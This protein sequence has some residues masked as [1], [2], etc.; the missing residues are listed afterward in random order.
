MCIRDRNRTGK[1]IAL[2]G[3][4]ADNIGYQCGGW[5]ITWQGGS[6]D[7]TPG[8]SILDAFKATVRDTNDISYSI[9]GANIPDSD[10]IIAV[11]GE[12]PYSE[13]WGDRNS[14]DLSE[15]NKKIVK[16]VKQK[17]FPI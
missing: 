13:G 4:H 16:R 2:V 9:D 1:K 6:G 8:T 3:D 10:I 17:I 14:L 5:T 12:K 15:E 11:I 7:I